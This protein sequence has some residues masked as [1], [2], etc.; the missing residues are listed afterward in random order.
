MKKPKFRRLV[1]RNKWIDWFYENPL[2][3]YN[4]VK[5]YFLPIKPKF[6][7]SFGKLRKARILEFNS[8]DLT[9]KDKFNSP[10]HEYNPRIFLSLFNYIHLYVEWTLEKDPMDDMVYWEAILDW[11]YYGKSLQEANTNG[12]T[13]YNKETDSYESMEFVSLKEPYQTMYKNKELNNI[14]YESTT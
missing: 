1:L 12:W 13:Q 8:F 5:E 2:T 14:Y 11:M 7:W 3:T 10:R 4:K 6:Q 9:W